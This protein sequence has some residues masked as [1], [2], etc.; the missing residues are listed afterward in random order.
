VLSSTR[1][2][3]PEPGRRAVLL[4][5][6]SAALLLF[7][8]APSALAQKP[9]P[10]LLAQIEKI[11]AI[12]DHSH[13]P[14]LVGPGEKDDEYDALPCDPLQ[15][16]PPPA[17]SRPENPQFLAAWKAL[18]GYPYNDMT[19]AHARWV[20]AA[21]ARIQKQQGDNYPDWVLDR[22]GIETELA[23]REAMGRGL[24]PPRFRWVPFDDA[25]LLP[26]NNDGLGAETPDRKFFYGR[27]TQLLARYMKTLGMTAPPASLD[28]YLAKVVTP[29]L[30]D[31]KKNGAVA[32]KFEAAYLRSLDFAPAS[33]A[34]AQAIYAR[35]VRGGT[36]PNSE[37]ITLQ[38]YI[39][40]YLAAEAG[41]LGMPVH[42]HTGFGCGGYFD[43]AG[44][45]PLLLE[46]VLDDPAL[47]HT[48]F[49]LLHGG[50]GMYSKG[51]AMLLVKPN[52]YTD[53]S[54]QTW[55]LPTYQL[56][57]N[58]RY[59]LELFPEKVMFGTDLYPNTP[60]INWEEVGWQTTHSA[61]EALAIALTGMMDDGE[62][63]RARA[64]VLAKMALREN[65][66][67]LYGWPDK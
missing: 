41:K 51:V 42:F 61:R 18:W 25:L 65:A 56:A 33:L 29:T 8:F 26:L 50:A 6:L 30:E 54:E 32:V 67:K 21:K 3:D 4:A 19:P 9:D 44:A 49:V 34:Q 40:R 64:L 11:R 31:Q 2:V 43:I 27:E 39:F 60:E 23:N 5:L 53:F 46:S 59:F 38:N 45:N 17:T 16:T 22:L 1:R 20:L 63:S 58:I 52:V 28:G 37:Y 57:K 35:Y 36:P 24:Q 10:Q 12:D 66:L 15:P 13:P 62:I 48:N 47:R 7:A 14:A 55:L